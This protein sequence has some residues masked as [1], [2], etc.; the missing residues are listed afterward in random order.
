[1]RTWRKT[2]SSILESERFAELSNGAACLFFM[3][4]VAQDDSGY[5]PW[6]NAKVKRLIVG[7]PWT[8][9]EA[10]EFAEE[11][12]EARMA[13]WEE[14]GGIVLRRG[15]E[16]NGL[17]RKDVTPELYP[18]QRDVNVY[19]A[20]PQRDVLPRA[21]QN[22]SRERVEEKIRDEDISSTS[23]T[24]PTWWNTLSEYPLWGDEVD[25]SFIR[26]VDSFY[27]H[28][29]LPIQARECLEWLRTKG[30][31]RKDI[32]RTW[33]NWLKRSEAT[34]TEQPSNGKIGAKEWIERHGIPDPTTSLVEGRSE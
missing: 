25:E 17:P 27:G 34:P 13:T 8:V 26:D 7:R 30:K 23:I 31:A 9:D 24:L 28:L 18:R 20:E 19:V 32:R 16:L 6:E 11:I 29:D 21:E 3:L 15:I 12:I 4:L 5:Y 10:T 14:N 1:M 2:H 22:K 33:L